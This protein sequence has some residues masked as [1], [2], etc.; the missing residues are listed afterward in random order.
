MQSAEVKRQFQFGGLLPTVFLLSNSASC[1]AAAN[2]LKLHSLD[3]LAK[4]LAS[5]GPMNRGD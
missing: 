3:K 5:A 1:V 4:G 2:P